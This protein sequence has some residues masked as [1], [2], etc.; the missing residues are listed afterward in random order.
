M[1]EEKKEKI[2]RVGTNFADQINEI[3]N[4]RLKR[5][6]DKKKI[7]DR[8]ITGLIPKHNFWGK[9]KE[10]LINFKFPDK[11]KKGLATIGIFE[12]I[13]VA[14]LILI[15]IGLFVYSFNYISSTL[16]INQMIGKVNMS[17][18]SSNTIGQINNA[19]LNKIN[20]IGIFLLFG[21]VIGLFVNAYFTRDEYPKI[22]IFIDIILLIMAYILAVYVSNSYETIINISPFDTIFKT[23][24]AQPSY[25]L[26]HL[27]LISVIIGIIIMIITY[28]GIPFNREEIKFMQS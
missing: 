13:I 9:I 28:S 24:M 2:I 3:R 16:N 17:E 8:K 25:F 22:F 4:E 20:L 10:D 5:N 18:A 26:L 23:N 12:F 15:V 14:F 7:S 11:N 6:I 21:M 19:I 27:P 1:T